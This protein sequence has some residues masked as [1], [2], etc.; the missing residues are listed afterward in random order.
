MKDIC[1]SSE[2][3]NFIRERCYYFD[4]AFVDLLKGY[5]YNPSEVLIKH[6][7]WDHSAAEVKNLIDGILKE[8][9]NAFSFESILFGVG[10]DAD[11]ESAQRLMGIK[12][13]AKIGQTGKEIRKMIGFI[14]ASISRSSG[15]SVQVMF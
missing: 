3:E 13:L 14:S 10:N 5:R 2:G 12:H 11:F 1:L 6:K 15:A 7:A 9:K 4:P 8:E